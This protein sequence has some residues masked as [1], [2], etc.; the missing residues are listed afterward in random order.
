VA[1]A[2]DGIASIPGV[3]HG[4]A[5]AE[6]DRLRAHAAAL[7]GALAPFEGRWAATG[8]VVTMGPFDLHIGRLRGVL[9][10][11]SGAEESLRR[12]ERACRT[13]GA[14]PWLTRCLVALAGL[15][16]LGDDERRALATEAHDL[17]TELG[18]SEVATHARQRLSSLG[19]VAL[20]AG[21]T[22]REG[23]VLA[24]VVSGASNRATAEQLFVSVKTVERHLLNGYSKLGV[25]TRTEAAAWVLRH[26]L[27]AVPEPERG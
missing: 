19:R 12:A 8:G 23:E 16:G 1:D 7:I 11:A 22:E 9:G 21:L 26:G 27:A 20:P 25:R 24:I 15:D 6:V 14:R 2:A 18:Q 5:S 3:E 4:A 10:D 17:A 13:A